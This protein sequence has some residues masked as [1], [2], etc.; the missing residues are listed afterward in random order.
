[1]YIG[2][3]VKYPLF[4]LHFN[5]TWILPTDFGKIL[6]YQINGNPFSGTDGQT[7]TRKLIVAFRNF[8]KAPKM[9]RKIMNVKNR[10]ARKLQT[11]RLNVVQ[12]RRQVLYEWSSVNDPI[13][14]WV[15]NRQT[16]HDCRQKERNMLACSFVR[17]IYLTGIQNMSKTLGFY[18][19]KALHTQML[20]DT[21][22]MK[23]KSEQGNLETY[24]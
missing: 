7:D 19:V 23:Y 8:A 10:R 3:H 5:E 1:M 24:F 20:H 22:I 4:L 15:L 6:N 11:Y 9:T 2:L 12:Q 16:K 14:N 13:H 17:V 18:G 21:F